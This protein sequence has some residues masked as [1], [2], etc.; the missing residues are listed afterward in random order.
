[1]DFSEEGIENWSKSTTKSRKTAKQVSCE[2]LKADL[3]RCRCGINLVD[4][5]LKHPW[6]V[7]SDSKIKS[8]G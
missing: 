1:M 6:V 3:V 7:L 8:G 5:A 4:G 2:L